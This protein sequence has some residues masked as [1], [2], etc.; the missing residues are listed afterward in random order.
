VSSNPFGST[1][2]SPGFWT[3]GRIDRN[4]HV[5]GNCLSPE[6]ADG[7]LRNSNNDRTRLLVDTRR[8]VESC[9]H[10]GLGSIC[11][12]QH[13][14]RRRSDQRRRSSVS[15]KILLAFF[16]VDKRC[17]M[18]SVVR[19]RASLCRDS[20]T[21]VRFHCR[22]RLSPRRILGWWI[23]EKDASDAESLLLPAREPNA[24]FADLRVVGV[25]QRRG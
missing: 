25:R 3:H 14:R 10:P 12:R 17:A 6:R 1:I 19:P 4:P 15:T 21:I 13:W 11:G 16:T 8:A 2:Q 23:F 7:L 18:T 9:R 24:A 20:W 22:L 5:R